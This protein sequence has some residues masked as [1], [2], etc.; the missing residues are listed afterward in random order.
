M[1]TYVTVTSW[2]NRRDLNSL[3][4][5][6]P[7]INIP[8]KLYLYS[9]FLT[10]SDPRDSSHE[11]AFYERLIEHSSLQATMTINDFGILQV[12]N[13]SKGS[14]DLNVSNAYATSAN[15]VDGLTITTCNPRSVP[16]R[17]LSTYT[18]KPLIDI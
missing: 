7:L 1:K 12:K 16:Y 5:F 10:S 6:C 9:N 11:I 14:D 17:F 13:E 2:L 8:A 4:F 18:G 15:P 3:T